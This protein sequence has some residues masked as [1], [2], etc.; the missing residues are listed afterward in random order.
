MM[1]ELKRSTAV[2]DDNT[3]FQCG[4]GIAEGEDVYDNDEDG[5]Y[6]HVSCYDSWLADVQSS[7]PVDAEEIDEVESEPS[8][9]PDTADEAEQDTEGPDGG[10]D[11]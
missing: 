10:D 8:E 3:C 5:Y 11:E 9:D 7:A 1:T 6:V 2:E 4:G